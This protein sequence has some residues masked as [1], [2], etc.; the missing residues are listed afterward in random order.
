MLARW[1]METRT[2]DYAEPLERVV[3]RFEY[4]P[5]AADANQPLTPSV[6]LLEL[7]TR[8][9]AVKCSPGSDPGVHYGTLMRFEGDALMPVADMAKAL[10][11]LRAVRG[12]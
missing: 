3:T 12:L 9:L 5:T 1:E 6:A 11:E 7:P 4:H 8:I 2:N 10:D